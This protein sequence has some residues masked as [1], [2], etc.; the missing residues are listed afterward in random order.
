MSRPNVR[1]DRPTLRYLDLIQSSE[2][3]KPLLVRATGQ[4]YTPERIGR[5]LARSVL[6]RVDRISDQCQIVDPFAGDGR[7]IVWLLEEGFAARP[8]EFASCR[9]AIDLWELNREALATATDAVR[10]A[11]QRLGIRATVTPWLG[12]TFSKDIEEQFDVVIT[13]PPWENLKPDRREAVDLQSGRNVAYANGLRDYDRFLADRFPLSRPQKRF[14]GWGTN[15]SRVGTE[16]ALR[17][18]RAGGTCGVVTPVSLFGDQAS[19]ALRRHL[20]T[21]R[22][23]LDLHSYPAEARLFDGVDQPVAFFVARSAAPNS[24]PVAFS[25]YRRDMSVR[26]TGNIRL[27][28]EWLR[29]SH[30]V[31][32]TEFGIEAMSLLPQFARLPRFADLEERHGLWAG[33]ELDETG[34]REFVRSSGKFRFVKGRH[35]GRYAIVDMPEG[36]VSGRKIPSTAE[37]ERIAWRDV[38]RPSQRRRIQASLIP[39]HWVS[40]NSLSVA[41]FKDHDRGKLL[42]LLAVLNSVVFELQIR[43]IL[44][45]GHVSLGSVRHG[46]VPD[47]FDNKRS[48]ERLARL[49]EKRLAQGSN[50]EAELEIAVAQAYGLSRDDFGAI[51]SCFDLPV[52][53]KAQLLDQARWS[54]RLP[55]VTSTGQLQGHVAPRLSDLDMEIVRHVPQ[56]G[57]WKNI[58]N[59]VPS[60]RLEQIRRSFAAGEGSRSTYYGRLKP[61]APAYTIST[62]FTRPG[63]GCHI[64]Y[65]QDRVLTF[66]EAARLQTFPDNFVFKGTYGSVAK[67]IGNAVPPVLA[68]QIARR[69][70]APAQFIDL[71]AG[72]GGLSLGFKWAG[73]SPVIANDI[74][75]VFLQTYAANV[76][77]AVVVGDMRDSTVVQTLLDHAS[78]AR[79]RNTDSALWVLGGPPCQGFS[80]A[81][82]RRSMDDERN[83]LFKNY[84]E[85]IGALEPD[86][87]VFE[88]VPGLLNMS[89]GRVFE[90]VRSTLSKC[91]PHL[92]AW[93]LR[94]EEYGVPQRRHRVLLVGAGG[95]IDPPDPVTSLTDRPR[96]LDHHIAPAI[97]VREA[98]GDLPPIAQGED[99]SSFDYVT[100]PENVYQEL[101]RSRITVDEYIPRLRERVAAA[102]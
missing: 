31:L 84:A 68:Y 40:G 17:L 69:V 52:E 33:R 45:T 42:A 64:H 11:A 59:S 20:I 72:A 86:G 23:L 49:T 5:Q 82:N 70:G 98:L 6:A 87:F 1:Y 16:L 4:F 76:H 96:L 21:E 28:V 51:V 62:Y 32:P 47:I 3:Q 35:V 15:L 66:R 22:T 44:S 58:P 89:E 55:R 14:S 81:G 12:D 75:P 38:S 36:F 2:R 92:Q 24:D 93:I 77:E 60:S 99:G 48:I 61:T 29:D 73:W 94:S 34:Y 100:G 95:R 26:Y 43:S 74:D 50:T 53:Y 67:Q 57:N 79:K 56:G 101:M 54:R 102:A 19:L 71:F 9:L 25:A 97:T 78:A 10:A 7:L 63:N 8:N 85:F 18:L 91:M 39:P 90:L 27:N 80:T 83:A 41:Y 46:H 65:D 37:H 30:F 13:N 88:N